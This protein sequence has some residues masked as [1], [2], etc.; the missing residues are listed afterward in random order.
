MGVK[1]SHN[2]IKSRT[3]KHTKKKAGCSYPKKTFKKTSGAEAEK[4]SPNIKSFPVVGIG[5]SAGDLKHF[6]TAGKF[7][8][9]LGMAY[10]YIQHLS[11]NHESFLSQILQRKTKMPVLEVKDKAA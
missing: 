8:A 2:K 4:H 1:K 9:D 5:G 10:V 11:P 7:T 3:K 6:P